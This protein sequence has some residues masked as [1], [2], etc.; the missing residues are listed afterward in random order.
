MSSPVLV[1]NVSKYLQEMNGQWIGLKGVEILM[2]KCPQN[3]GQVEY[4]CV[5]HI[6]GH[7]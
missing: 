3:I 1:L 7:L 2:L 6:C 4:M 5:L